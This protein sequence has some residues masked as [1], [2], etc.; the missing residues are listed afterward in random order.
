MSGKDFF[1]LKQQV[2]KFSV[3]LPPLPLKSTMSINIH[4]ILFAI[5]LHVTRPGIGR[6]TSCTGMGYFSYTS[7]P[8]NFVVCS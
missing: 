5:H 4:I 6:N 8:I 7:R 2:M 1:Q 3:I